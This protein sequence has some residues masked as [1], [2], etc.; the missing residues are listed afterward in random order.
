MQ[1][2]W[3]RIASEQL[4]EAH[5]FKVQGEHKAWDEEQDEQVEQRS[6]IFADMHWLISSVQLRELKRQGLTNQDIASRMG[7]SVASVQHR[8]SKIADEG[9]K[10]KR[11]RFSKTE[12]KLVRLT[13]W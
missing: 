11:V 5:A 9:E 10:R 4:Y 1:D 7:R 2:R 13:C 6:W 8:W 12:D 3:K